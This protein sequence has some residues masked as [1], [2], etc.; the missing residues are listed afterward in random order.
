MKHQ[1]VPDEVE[2]GA[3]LKLLHKAAEGGHTLAM[4]KL[5]EYAFRGGWIVEA[6]YWT[7]LAQ[8]HG[9]SG[10]DAA[11]E[12]FRRIWLRKGCPAEHRNVRMGFSLTQGAFARAALRLKCG[13]DVSLARKRMNELKRL[14]FPEALLYTEG[15]S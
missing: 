3:Y 2:D 14:N 7:L 13:L 12:E 9:K 1:F 8:L 5:G 6:Y 4:V 10:L 15:S 11:L